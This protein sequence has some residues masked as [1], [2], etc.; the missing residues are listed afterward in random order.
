MQIVLPYST[1]TAWSLMLTGNEL[2]QMFGNEARS[3]YLVEVKR[4]LQSG[5]IIIRPTTNGRRLALLQGDRKNGASL[6][7]SRSQ[8]G[9]DHQAPTTQKLWVSPTW[10]GRNASIIIPPIFLDG[11]PKE[12]S[13]DDSLRMAIKT[14]N[15]A[16]DTDP[17]LIA[18]VKSVSGEDAMSI[19]LTRTVTETIS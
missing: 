5:V 4:D 13:P 16:L 6:T 8:F 7:L 1:K 15:A 12:Q 10:N 3:A 19:V 18:Q 9:I 17:T 14:V 11:I 2:V